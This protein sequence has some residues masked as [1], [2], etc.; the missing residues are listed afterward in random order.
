MATI[1][2]EK[3]KNELIEYFKTSYHIDLKKGKV[4]TKQEE[5][6]WNKMSDEEK[7]NDAFGKLPL[8]ILAYI[9][10]GVVLVGLTVFV[11][12]MFGQVD[13]IPKDLMDGILSLFDGRKKSPKVEIEEL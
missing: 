2:D 7:F 5:D 13:V 8:A 1:K 6:Q 3:F 4:L 9:I 12:Q 11:L 10:E